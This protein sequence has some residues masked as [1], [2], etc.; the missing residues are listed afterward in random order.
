[1]TARA[2]RPPTRAELG[3]HRDALGR[4]SFGLRLDRVRI[5]LD[6]LDDELA[7]RL[8]A[9]FA[10]FAGPIHAGEDA[11]RV[12]VGREERDYFIDPPEFPESNPVLTAVE[13][14]VVRYLGYRVGGWF[15]PE[16]GEGVLWLARGEYEPAERAVENYLRCAV[17]C[18][19]VRSGGALVHAA[20]SVRNGYGFLFFGNSGAGKSTL[21]AADR[22]GRIV[23]DDL[24]LV[25][26]GR[27]AGLDLVGTPF[28]GTYEGG[29]MVHGRFPLAAGFRLAQARTA[30]V[31]DVPRRVAFAG[32]VANLPFVVDALD[33]DPG[34]VDR[35]RTAFDSIPLR[36]LE[37]RKD[38]TFWDA[39]EEAG[40]LPAAP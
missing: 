9:R 19:A 7:D 16:G 24:S 15:E 3:E 32:L 30:R 6:G 10:G 23:S 12:R 37:F 38:D 28:R 35:V 18:R 14:G 13:P 29:A 31:R 21:A 22:R 20:S 27:E 33:A 5:R 34:A 2:R 36:V 25:L 40:L 1:M 17:A 26:P 39:I 8:A 4:R 11:I